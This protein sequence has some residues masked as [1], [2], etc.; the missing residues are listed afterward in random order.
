M[1]E[2]QIDPIFNMTSTH[3][4]ASADNALVSNSN[5]DHKGSDDSG[6]SSDANS[7]SDPFEEQD[8]PQAQ[9]APVST[10]QPAGETDDD[11]AMTFGSEGEGDTGDTEPQNGIPGTVAATSASQEPASRMAADAPP[12]ATSA[13][14][15][16]G[17]TISAPQVESHSMEVSAAPLSARAHNSVQGYKPSTP[18]PI[19]KSIQNGEIDIQQLLDNITA[20]AELGAANAAPNSASTSSP[21]FPPGSSAFSHTSLPPRPQVLSKPPMHPAYAPQNGI[22]KYHAG[23]TYPAPPGTTP[24]APGLPGSLIAAG[25]PG[26]HTDPRNGLP[27]PPAASFN[28]PPTS[29]SRPGENMPFAPQRGPQHSRGPSSADDGEDE[30]EVQWG[31][32]VQKL[33]DAFLAEE[34]RN[35]AEGVWDRFPMGSRLF[36]GK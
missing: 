22:R 20:N 7:F 33:Y 17:R 15:E 29:F 32:D 1:L 13:P 30:G 9:A 36:I 24:R 10:I 2:K 23:S 28:S 26:T 14:A 5:S 3:T 31:P 19:Y 27:P 25:A 12:A 4:G 8:V 16:Q 6:S 18:P 21:T 11:Y 35:V 34:C